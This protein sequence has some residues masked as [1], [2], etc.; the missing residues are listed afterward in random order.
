[1]ME[2]YQPYH[3]RFDEVAAVILARIRSGE[4]QP[5]DRLPPER[6]LVEE[7]GVSRTVVREALRSLAA[8]G[9]IDSHVGRGTFVR[10]PTLAHLAAEIG[11]FFGRTT[12]ST[13]NLR[14]ARLLVE[15]MLAEHALE[16]ADDEA[17][18]E[19][20][21][22][23]TRGEDDAFYD[24][25]AA[26]AGAPLLGPLLAALCILEPCERTAQKSSKALVAAI[27]ARDVEAV[28]EAL[29]STGK[30]AATPLGV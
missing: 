7:F 28:G 26:A 19:V 6:K 3:R 22:A 30:R 17:L 27:R 21:Q 9:L 15:Q 29:V 23:H 14:S 2:L 4:L 16:N 8:Q 10:K 1:M 24:A 11:L 12:A 20:V 18:D 25:L 13:A 5:G